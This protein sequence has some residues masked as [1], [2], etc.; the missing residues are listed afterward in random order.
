MVVCSQLALFVT[1]EA[2]P[3]NVQAG[4][5][6]YGE[7]T[8]LKGDDHL[9]K[10]PA[11]LYMGGGKSGKKETASSESAPRPAAPLLSD[12][13]RDTR[14]SFLAS[15]VAFFALRCF[16]SLVDVFSAA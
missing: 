16:F 11:H 12:A 13:L 14:I 2:L 7:I 15:C 8:L 1:P 9:A 4:D 5:C 3:S 10:I 6:L